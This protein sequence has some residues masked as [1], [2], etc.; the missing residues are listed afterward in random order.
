MK[1]IPTIWPF[2]IWG[3]DMVGKLA[4]V[5][6]GFT[7]PLVTVTKFTK[8]IE[9]KPITNCDGTTTLKNP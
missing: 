5:I 1:T 2:V 3:L 6:C 8:W 4:M 7:H 9:A